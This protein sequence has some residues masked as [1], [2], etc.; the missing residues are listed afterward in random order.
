VYMAAHKAAEVILSDAVKYG[1][2][3]G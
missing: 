3:N 2:A 1:V